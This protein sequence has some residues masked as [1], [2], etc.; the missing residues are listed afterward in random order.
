MKFSA[1]HQAA[2]PEPCTKSRGGFGGEEEGEAALAS[3]T[4]RSQ[5]PSE[6]LTKRWLICDDV[7]KE[8]ETI[9]E[10]LGRL[11]SSR[12]FRSARGKCG[13]TGTP[14]VSLK[15]TSIAEEVRFFVPE[16]AFFFEGKRSKS[17]DRLDFE[18][19]KSLFSFSEAGG[20]P[21]FLAAC[22][23]FRFP[24]SVILGKLSLASPRYTIS[25]RFLVT[26]IMT[27]AAASAAAVVI[28]GGEPLVRP[29]IMDI[30]QQQP[31]KSSKTPR[32]R[33]TAS[34][35]LQSFTL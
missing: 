12:R 33:R 16:Q 27:T 30:A 22:P 6:L 18:K 14:R 34:R 28:A 35:S 2:C 9:V 26:K 31:S 20:A 21:R 17:V 25:V 13:V 15:G 23:T 4:S 24:R 29:E 5:A 32:T 7:F 8:A 1:Q 11:R 3:R 19:K 10:F